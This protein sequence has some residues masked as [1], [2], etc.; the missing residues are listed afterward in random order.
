GAGRF[1]SAPQRAGRAP[2]P[3]RSPG[4]RPE[5]TFRPRCPVSVPPGVAVTAAAA[6]ASTQWV[7]SH[8]APVPSRYFP[9][10]IF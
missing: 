10:H 6:T 1:P 2:A 7:M 5:G 4:K 8:L 9:N 3:E